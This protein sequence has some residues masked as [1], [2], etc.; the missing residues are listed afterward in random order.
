MAA[1]EQ[2]A[3]DKGCTPGQLSLAWLLAKAPDVIPIPGTKREAAVRENL[4]AAALVLSA[5]DVARLEAAVPAGAV[6]GDRYA[7][8]AITYAANM[9]G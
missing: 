3:A 1:V 8:M 6:V 9:D 7:H 4:A 2:M 5:E